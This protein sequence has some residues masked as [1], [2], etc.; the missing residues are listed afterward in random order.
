MLFVLCFFI[1]V[2]A[3]ISS[4]SATTPRYATK[5]HPIIT[6][7]ALNYYRINDTDLAS[8]DQSD[9]DQ[10][11]IGSEDEDNFPRYLNHYFDYFHI[12]NNGGSFRYRSDLNSAKDWAHN[13]TGQSTY[14]YGGDHTWETAIQ[15]MKGGRRSAAFESLGHILHLVQDMTLPSHTRNDIH[16]G[17]WL[18]NQFTSNQYGQYID[19]Y[20]DWIYNNYRDITNNILDGYASL[21]LRSL[22]DYFILL[23]DNTQRHYFSGY[24]ATGTAFSINY[25]KDGTIETIFPSVIRLKDELYNGETFRFAMGHDAFNKEIHLAYMIKIGTYEF[26][27]AEHPIIYRDTWDRAGRL[28]MQ[29][30]AGVV[31]LFLKEASSSAPMVRTLTATSVTSYGATLNGSVNPSASLTTSLF[32][33]GTDP[34]LLGASTTLVQS[35]GGGSS[36]IPFTV[37]L[38]G[39]QDNTTYYFRLEARNSYGTVV[40][41]I[42][43]FTTPLAIFEING[44]IP[45]LTTY[46]VFFDN[47]THVVAIYNNSSI[48]RTVIVKG[49]PGKYKIIY[50]AMPGTSREQAYAMYDQYGN[51]VFDLSNGAVV[52][53]GST[54][55]DSGNGR[56][57]VNVTGSGYLGI[58]EPAPDVHGVWDTT[59]TIT[60]SDSPSFTVGQINTAIDNILQI[61]NRINRYNSTIATTL[62]GCING[63]LIYESVSFSSGG[64]NNYFF[65]TASVNAAGNY[66]FGTEQQTGTSFLY[67]SY[68]ITADVVRT[69][70]P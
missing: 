19:E 66:M 32:R 5:S 59:E 56:V 41:A 47:N 35:I 27:S 70:R 6:D 55:L 7:T 20:E 11:K 18:I 1:C 14:P 40:G 60:S 46:S 42:L 15:H 57:F 68:K 65:D 58:Y 52:T 13:K 26:W 43:S 12:N 63:D 61:G 28:A 33:Y 4:G 31:K 10:L 37:Q 69:K 3:I 54:T 22:D 23:S 67:G 62:N 49:P 30:T 51:N 29:A 8:I 21:D 17:G 50:I 16:V 9:I 38:T 24:G 48:S 36:S 53:M 44:Q 25:S 64:Y 39:L 45:P 2:I 34:N